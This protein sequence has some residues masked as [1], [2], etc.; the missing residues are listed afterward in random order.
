[1][2]DF[3]PYDTMPTTCAFSVKKNRSNANTLLEIPH[4][5]SLKSIHLTE[6]L[7]ASTKCFV[8]I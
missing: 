5:K 4:V 1:M 3:A 8:V 2:H 7:Y 6:V